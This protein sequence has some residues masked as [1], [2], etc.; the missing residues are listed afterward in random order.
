MKRQVFVVAAFAFLTVGI[1]SF[2]LGAG[3]VSDDSASGA[4]DLISMA[5]S[6]V[7]E[8]VLETYIATSPQQYDLSADDIITL[9]DLGVSSKVIREALVHG[10]IMD[11]AE[12]HQ[13]VREATHDS[14][15]IMQQLTTYSSNAPPADSLNT[16]LFYESLN[17]Y[18]NW[19]EV[20]GT[21]CWQPNAEVV[22]SDWAPY[23][24]RGHWEYSDWGWCWVSD[25]SW[26][27][28]PFHYGRWL[29]HREYGWC[30][31]PD[32]QW[33]PAWVSW[34][35]GSDY[36]GWAPLPPGARYVDGQGFYD[37]STLA[38]DDYEFGLTPDDYC[39]VPNNHFCDARP[40]NYIVPAVR[41][42]QVYRSTSA[43]KNSYSASQGHI[44]NR[45]LPVDFVS[46]ATGKKI[47]VVTVNGAVVAPGQPILRSIV[48]GGRLTIYK[49]AVSEKAPV[50]PTLIKARFERTPHVVVTRTNLMQREQAAVAQTITA[51]Q[52]EAQGAKLEQTNLESA[53]RQEMDARKRAELQSEA[54]VR[55]MRVQQAESHVTQIRKWSP[56]VAP[57]VVPQSRV[58]SRQQPQSRQ[59]VSAQV[60][61]VVQQ[62]AHE[63]LQRKQV[64]EDMVRKPLSAQPRAVQQRVEPKVN[65]AR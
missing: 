49:P 50:S 17:P 47:T 54:E 13:T 12:A 56:P 1:C 35:S 27:W 24:N 65:Q 7:D 39:F 29:R 10:R 43:V 18:G 52:T 2:A 26:G 16:S 48:N 42:A 44:L 51:K 8:A 60:R 25:Y 5:R 33:G 61:S 31:V 36:S 38:G 6:G 45:G 19:I 58:I 37:G 20:N 4:A 53:A 41:T 63:E 64:M 28:A 55:Q 22:N 59:Q 57:V 30:W 14:A 62:E 21:W 11:T 23:S 46:A 9:K 40:A 34:R 3:S 32:T 15:A